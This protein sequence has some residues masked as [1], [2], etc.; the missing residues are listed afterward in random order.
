MDKVQF[1][2]VN[3]GKRMAVG[4]EHAGARVLCPHCRQVVQAPAANA[5]AGD[6]VAVPGSPAVAPATPL[7]PAA[8]EGPPIS[9][10]EVAE[11][12]SIFGA[13]EEEHSDA[14]FG[15][16][17][18]PRIELPGPAQPPGPSPPPTNES[19]SV[20][21]ALAAPAPFPSPVAPS[22]PQGATVPE[23]PAAPPSSDLW[24]EVVPPA[25]VQEHAPESLPD[26][27]A[28][29]AP[30]R[31]VKRSMLVPT[32]L[33]FLIPYSV[34]TTAFIVW[35][36]FSQ[37]GRHHPYE[38]MIDP[39]PEDG[40]PRK[41]KEQIQH[42]L[43]VPSKLRTSLEQALQ[44]GDLEVTPLNVRLNDEGDLV[45]HLK[46]RN[47]SKD[48]AFNPLPDSFLHG[49]RKTK[50]PANI[51][52]FLEVGKKDRF[53]GGYLEYRKGPPGKEEAYPNGILRPGQ[54]M[55]ALLTTE[56]KYRKDVRTVMKSQGP[57]LWRVQVRRG[58]LPFGD[59]QRSAT[60]VVGIEFGTG[61]IERPKGRRS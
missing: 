48:L 7:S 15:E 30:R 23:A 47:I 61:S 36:L 50:G 58:L 57:L 8:E 13:S 6:T 44:I 45:L 1:Q 29:L 43:E 46:M 60:A 54:E 34:F 22:E 9:V 51:Y 40:G 59:A 49:A 53:Y 33:V 3:C 38:G 4:K 14:L 31:L 35:Q 19:A 24:K 41:L 28:P 56:D 37:R 52:T 10:P 16:S 27:A 55:V 17:P 20:T 18:A 2:C 5:A 25:P 26:M 32:L 11:R 12:E 42:D 39:R 21:E